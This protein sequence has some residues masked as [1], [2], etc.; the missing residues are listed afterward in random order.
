MNKKIGIVMLLILLASL[1]ATMNVAKAAAPVAIRY[2]TIEKIADET[3]L[4]GESGDLYNT[5][6]IVFTFALFRI[7]TQNTQADF[8][9]S[10]ENATA[11]RDIAWSIWLASTTP[12]SFIGTGGG[13]GFFYMEVNNS[14]FPFRSQVINNP[15]D[16]IQTY[17]FYRLHVWLFGSV[18]ERYTVRLATDIAAPTTLAMQLKSTTGSLTGS[19]DIIKLQKQT[20]SGFTFKHVKKF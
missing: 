4:Y 18:G 15:I 11:V 2:T 17:Y 19:E 20:D 6:H 14:E 13:E 12:P 9:T 10:I 1:S 16:G 5:T 8:T 3:V 7:D